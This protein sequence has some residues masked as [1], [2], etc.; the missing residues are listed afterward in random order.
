M[1]LGTL[2]ACGW[3][4]GLGLLA[5][6]AP[7]HAARVDANSL[8]A[9]FLR[10]IATLSV[11]ADAPSSTSDTYVI[12]VLGSDPNGVMKPIEERVDSADPLLVEGRQIRIVYLDSTSGP[13]V[14]SLRGCDMLFLSE[15]SRE[16]WDQVAP[17]IDTVPIVTVGEFSG[18]AEQGGMIEYFVDAR[19]S[20]VR[21]RVNR[22]AAKRAGISLSSRL[23]ALNTVIIVP[24]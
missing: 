1:S 4:A 15:D 10:H 18:F 24:D 19:R 20:Q 8:K 6:A 7:C 13:G 2:A 3:M 21:M 16:L 22:S 17:L 9:A 5:I 12:G 23:L 11:P 14:D